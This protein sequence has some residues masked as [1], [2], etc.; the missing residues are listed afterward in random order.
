MKNLKKNHYRL[1]LQLGVLGIL[2]YLGYR[3]ISR[4][5]LAAD[6]EAY[7]PFGGLQ[8]LANFGTNQ[9][10]ACSMTSAQIA[11]GLA[12]VV[13]V[14]FFGK[15]FC[16]YVCPL[17][18][19]T[20]WLGNIGKRLRVHT[21]L[22]GF[23][24]KLLRL[25]KYA[26]LLVV[27]YFT[28]QT[29]ELF[30]KTFDPFFAAATGFGPDVETWMAL[31][32]ISVL[33]LGS[34]FFRMFWCKYACPLGALSNIFMFPIPAFTLVLVYVG[35]TL[36]GIQLSFFYALIPLALLGYIGEL[37][38]RRFGQL[39]SLKITRDTNTC[40]DCKKC[41][42]ACPQGIAVSEYQHVSH[43]DCHN[44]GECLGV[45]P[46]DQTLGFNKTYRTRWVPAAVVVL[47]FLTGLFAGNQFEIP[48]VRTFWGNPQLKGDVETLKMDNLRDIKCYGSSMAFVNHMKQVAG[49]VGVST[50]VKNHEVKVQ[51]D[52]NRT[53]QTKIKKAIFSPARMMVKEPSPATDSMHVIRGEINNFFDAY[54]NQFMTQL[55]ENI[56]GIYGF[57]TFYGEPVQMKIYTDPNVE[58]DLYELRKV[59]EKDRLQ[60]NQGG[61]QHQEEL[62]FDVVN[63]E[64]TQEKK[65]REAFMQTMYRSYDGKANHRDTYEKDEIAVFRVKV[66][67]YPKNLQRGPHLRNDIARNDTG[68]V[69]VQTYYAGDRPVAEIE[70]VKDLTDSLQVWQQMSKDTLKLTYDNGFVQRIR[71]P[72]TFERFGQTKP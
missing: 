48:T 64:R 8:A 3:V 38:G 71:N 70:Y 43:I 1:L 29:S 55:L 19:I 13:A 5:S 24:D 28:L 60:Y 23:A 61:V 32:S 72:Y 9:S 59:M 10:L 7:C 58:V 49:V 51:Y 54:D 62:N 65:G 17:G 15:L 45:C 39:P 12:L 6:F 50:F 14:I 34:I 30:C 37:T 56:P 41:D 20:E 47:L 53:N 31:V 18:T 57:E 33:V 27:F 36:L 40:I 11:M 21:T 68:I 63:L 46:V 16:S 4:G 22:T 66:T 44:C 2:F 42:Q 25:V 35:M 52:P 26:L 67:G 69:R